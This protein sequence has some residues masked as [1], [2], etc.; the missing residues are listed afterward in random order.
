MA[1]ISDI[2]KKHVDAA[3]A[4]AGETGYPPH[5]VARTLLTFAI[6]IWR[7]GRDTKEIVDELNYVLDNLD[8]DREYTFMRP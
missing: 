1:G 2:V 4:E 3:V 6:Q 5:D 7:E 8:P